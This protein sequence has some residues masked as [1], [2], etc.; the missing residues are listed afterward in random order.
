MN[1][2]I[3][4]ARECRRLGKLGRRSSLGVAGKRCY[5]QPPSNRE[6]LASSPTHSAGWPTLDRPVFHVPIAKFGRCNWRRRPALA[7][8]R[9]ALSTF[10][11]AAFLLL[12]TL[13]I[14]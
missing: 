6:I 14:S 4:R 7:T 11:A 10:P 8:S 9:P 2:E 13:D 5:R 3:H 1:H 12:L